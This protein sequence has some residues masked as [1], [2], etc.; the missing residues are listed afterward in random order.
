MP[1]AKISFKFSRHL[2][3]GKGRPCFNYRRTVQGFRF[4]HQ[5]SCHGQVQL[6]QLRAI[7]LPRFFVMSRTSLFTDQEKN[8]GRPRKCATAVL[9]S[10]CIL[11][12]AALLAQTG[13]AVAQATGTSPARVDTKG[14]TAKIKFEQIIS[15]PFADLNGKFKL[16]V[17][18]LIL[19]TGGVRRGTQPRWSRKSPGHRRRYDLRPS[20]SNG[21]LQ[22]RRLLF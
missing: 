10:I 16:R 2:G 11:P 7:G 3:I 21:Y 17:T 4:D 20:R 5:E 19:R 9:Q 12:I 22:T 1:F 14:L 18:E 13:N 8:H 15:G 6:P